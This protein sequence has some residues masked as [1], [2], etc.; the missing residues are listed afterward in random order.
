[1]LQEHHVGCGKEP[2]ALNPGNDK[3]FNSEGCVVKLTSKFKEYLIAVGAVAAAIAILEV[4]GIIFAFC[5]AHSLR[6][7]YRVV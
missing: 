4:I 3:I 2:G 5:L 1:L 6:K 7:D